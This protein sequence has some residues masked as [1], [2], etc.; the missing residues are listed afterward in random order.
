MPLTVNARGRLWF[1]WRACVTK[2]AKLL[3]SS[4]ETCQLRLPRQLQRP[5]VPNT[6][7]H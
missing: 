3:S 1:I 7:N 5:Y 4:T 2:P 6:N